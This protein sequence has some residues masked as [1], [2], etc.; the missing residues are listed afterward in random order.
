MTETMAAYSRILAHA[1]VIV[2]RQYPLP[3]CSASGFQYFSFAILL[4]LRYSF[5]WPKLSAHV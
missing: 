2:M 5:F 4:F 3:G 1:C